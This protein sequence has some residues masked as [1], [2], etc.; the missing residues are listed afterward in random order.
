MIDQWPAFQN[1]APTCIRLQAASFGA[2]KDPKDTITCKVGG[3]A[4]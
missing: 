4:L 1:L 2:T 3:V